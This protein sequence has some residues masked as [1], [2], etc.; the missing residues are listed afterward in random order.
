VRPD[1]DDHDATADRAATSDEVD[2]ILAKISRSGEASLTPE[3][4]QTL[5]DVS[6]RL[7]ER[8]R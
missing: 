6:R 4:R 1:D 8:S 2:R 7:R 3:E 5:T